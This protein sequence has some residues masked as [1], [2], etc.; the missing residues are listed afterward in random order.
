MTDLYSE[1]REFYHNHVSSWMRL[2][3]LRAEC[4]KLTTTDGTSPELLLIHAMHELEELQAEVERLREELSKKGMMMTTKTDEQ[5]RA[6]RDMR[7]AVMD[8][9]T[10]VHDRAAQIDEATDEVID[11]VS[12]ALQSQDREEIM[13]MALCESRRLVLRIG[14]AYR[15]TPMDGCKTC[16]EMKDEH[17]QTYSIDHARRI[18]GEA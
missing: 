13:E 5:E 12:A 14:Q 18:E 8:V 9:I 2:E 11:L 1:W 3:E 7:K 4:G 16:E 17:D 6:Y 10:D 15:F